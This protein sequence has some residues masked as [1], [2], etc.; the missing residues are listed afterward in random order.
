MRQCLLVGLIVAL[1][2]GVTTGVEASHTGW[3][4]G[5]GGDRITLTM[6]EFSFNPKTITV[7][8]GTPVEIVIE[9]KGIIS[10]VFMVYPK[11]KVAPK[12][13]GE[14]WEY[15]M[16]K[17][18]LQ[19]MGEIMVHVRGEWVVAG[20]RLSEVTL[21]PGKKATL[22]FVPRRKGTFEFGCHLTSGGASHYNAGMKGTFIV[23]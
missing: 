20:T 17:G 5:A 16:A 12:G 2:T 13:T 22:T 18:Y 11:P 6:A 19:D 1:I 7:H 14:W 3:V 9:N 23:K 21:E 4:Y 8:A 10:H 15:V